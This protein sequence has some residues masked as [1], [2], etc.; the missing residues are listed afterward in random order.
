MEINNTVF[1]S[2]SPCFSI[3]M[4]Y[5]LAKWTTY[6]VVCEMQCKGALTALR[7]VLLIA[8]KYLTEKNSDNFL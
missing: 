4:L 2:F 8:L 6:I 3:Q 5:L 1:L 7:A